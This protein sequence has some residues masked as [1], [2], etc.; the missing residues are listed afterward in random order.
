MHMVE[1]AVLGAAEIEATGTRGIGVAFVTIGALVFFLISPFIVGPRAP[2][3]RCR[4]GM[5]LPRRAA[6]PRAFICFFS[7]ATALV[8]LWGALPTPCRAQPPVKRIGYLEAGPFWLFDRTWSAFRDA[9]ARSSDI[10]CEFPPDARISP[11]WEP[12]QMQTLSAQAS[13][14]MQRTDLDMVVGMGTAAVKALLSA[15]TGRV[16]ILGMGM[17]DPIAAGVVSSAVDSGV[18]NF[19]CRV[20][21]DRWASMFRVFYEVVHFRKLGIMFADNPEGRVYAALADARAM[22][23]EL[24]FSLVLYGGLS[25]AESTEECAKGLESLYAQGMD[26]FFIGPLNC[27][28]IESDNLPRLL[29]T[30]TGWNV[31]TFARDGSEYVKAGALMGFSTWDFGPIGTFLAVQGHAILTGTLPR[32]VSM[33]DKAEPSIAL[34]LATAKAIGFDFPF[35]VLV[36]ADELHEVITSPRPLASP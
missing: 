30:L 25:S 36:V 16:P 19:T 28:D 18:D 2:G 26:A 12:E 29:N 33:L 23:S 24:G 32:S 6:L 7:A 35:D 11:G 17:A 15:N 20:T 31:P 3:V 5:R 10:R 1:L 27:F 4:V 9:L 8:F 34:N 21:V 14:L 13:A 22:A